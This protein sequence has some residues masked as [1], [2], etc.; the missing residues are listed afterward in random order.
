MYGTI[1]PEMQ[2]S[3]TDQIINKWERSFKENCTD[4]SAPSENVSSS[5]SDAG[6]S[7][8][9]HKLIHSPA[10]ETLLQLEHT[11]AMAV[12]EVIKAWDNARD[13]M[14]KRSVSRAEIVC[15]GKF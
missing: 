14:Q 10:L 15:L 6:F 9:Y 3:E 4:F 2:G 13:I 8:V 12:D 7:E 1:F 5:Y 11:Y